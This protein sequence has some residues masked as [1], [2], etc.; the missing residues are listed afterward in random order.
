[1]SRV[2]SIERAFT[3][4]GVLGDGPLGVTGVAERVGLPKSTVAR[5]LA[6]LAAEGVVEQVADGTDYR[7]GD[8]LALLAAGVRPTRSLVAVARPQ[9]VALA[10]ATGEAAGLSI[11]DGTL[12]HY[13][14]H[15]ESPHPV[16]I[17]DWTG[18]RFPM[19]TVSAGFVILAARR[20]EEVDRFLASPLERTTPWT[21]VD[22]VRLRE[23]IA[24]ARADGYAWTRDE[25]A[26]GIASC[27]AAVADPSGEVIAAVHVHG[28]AYRFPAPDD[29]VTRAAIGALVVAA[30]ARVSA[31]MRRA[32]P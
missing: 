32:A 23:R 3:V 1:M 31:S 26:E 30:A 28:P 11:P 5:L 22:P 19:H 17:R 2:Q 6:A 4:L 14:D 13:L 18:S 29:D 9:L 15:A 24:R 8:R 27:A 7:I 20:A 21:E 12:I 25:A 10:Q 16:G